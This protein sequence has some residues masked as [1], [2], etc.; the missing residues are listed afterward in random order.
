VQLKITHDDRSAEVLPPSE[1]RRLLKT[2]GLILHTCWAQVGWVKYVQAALA[3]VSAPPM[4]DIRLMWQSRGKGEQWDCAEW[5]QSKMQSSGFVDVRVAL[6]EREHRLPSAQLMAEQ[7]SMMQA[8]FTSSWTEEMKREKGPLLQDALSDAFKKDAR[9]DG[10][11]GF[12]MTAIL[13][14]GAKL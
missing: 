2:S 3:S 7:F 4:R 13:C 11:V 12:T 9:E 8:M 1:T 5:V 6:C 14:T 10:S